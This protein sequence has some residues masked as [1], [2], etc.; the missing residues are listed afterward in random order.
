VGKLKCKIISHSFFA[1]AVTIDSSNKCQAYVNAQTARQWLRTGGLSS[2]YCKINAC[3]KLTETPWP[4]P[5]IPIGP[6]RPGTFSPGLLIT[7]KLPG[8]AIHQ[9]QN[10]NKMDRRSLL[11][12]YAPSSLQALG[13]LCMHKYIV[14]IGLA[15]VATGDRCLPH[16]VLSRHT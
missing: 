14:F 3:T 7:K 4:I 2:S 9:Y 16:R 6:S 1:G 15:P 5:R 10:V 12:N 11:Y 13:I 8:K